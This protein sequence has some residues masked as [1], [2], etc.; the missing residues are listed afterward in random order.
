M[1]RKVVDWIWRVRGALPIAPDLSDDDAFDRLDSL[2]L[3]PG[4]SRE[5]ASGSLVFRKKDP[6]AQDKMAVFD[7]GALR[8]ERGAA[9]SVL[10]YELTSRALLFCFLAPLLFL[11]FAQLTKELAKFEAHPAV[12]KKKPEVVRA[13]NP[14]DKF[15]GAPAPEK[16]KA[17]VKADEEGVDD[18]EGGGKKPSPTPAYVF[19]GIFTALYLIGRALEARLVKTLFRRRLEGLNDQPSP[20][21]AGD[22][23][24]STPGWFERI[25]R[26]PSDQ[27]PGERHRPDWQLGRLAAWPFSR[28]AGP[29]AP[30]SAADQRS[31]SVQPCQPGR[32]DADAP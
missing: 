13:L 15:L 23:P 14:V 6:A 32:A 21:V 10:R 3:Q 28:L 9:G 8:V 1:N 20:A 19:A 29:A 18:D 27:P 7:A 31:G 26:S 2:F 24:T 12:T 22:A 4:T 30:R 17:K 11:S 5:R 16:P 25:G